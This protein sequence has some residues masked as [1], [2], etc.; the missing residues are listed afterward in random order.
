[1]PRVGQPKS[2]RTEF[3]E[4]KVP[5]FNL[6]L[7]DEEKRAVLATLESNW[8]TSGPRISEFE[9]AFA[10]AMDRPGIQAVA[11]ANCTVA[12][13]LALA[14]LDIKPGDEV[15]CPSLTFVATANAIRYAGATP[16]FADV[17]SEDE[18]TID[19]ADLESHITDKTRAIIVMHYGGYSCRM[20][21]ILA[22]AKT[23]RLKVVEDACHGP[24]GEYETQKLGTLGDVGCFSFFSNKNMTTGEGGMVVT[25]SQDLAARIRLMRSHGMT[26]TTYDRFRGHAFGY[27]VTTLGYNYRMDEIRAALGIEQ[28]KK[29]PGFNRDR[30]SRVAHYRRTL[31]QILPEVRIPF[32]AWNGRHGYHIFPVLLPERCRDRERVMAALAEQGIQ[33]SIHYRPVH[34]FTDFKDH[35]ARL[36]KT[37]LIA[38]RILTLPLYPALSDSQIEL[39][40]RTLKTCLG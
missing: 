38:P 18:W 40:V 23:H 15:I 14:A 37:E 10:E 27:D 28:L 26:T 19:P 4:W 12:L 2:K 17:C 29:L 21:E 31:G 6:S 1:M 16:V 5:F 13:H 36:P 3:V 32:A 22:I 30:Q 9:T 34:T 35:G 33:T 39:V 24:L 11:V 7:G 25:P 8:L 20:K